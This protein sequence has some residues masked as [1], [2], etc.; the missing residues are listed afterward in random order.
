MKVTVRI[1]NSFKRQAKPLLKKYPSLK[2]DL[3]QLEQDL[4]IN[5]KMGN[6]LGQDSYKIRLATKSKNKGKSGGLRVISHLETEILSITEFDGENITLILISI[7][8]KGE[9]ATI[10][11]KELKDFINN[12][13]LS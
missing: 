5:P 10:S 12:I 9:T 8:N 7:Y 6:H 11:D 3:A 4:I 2:Q 13:K 1:A